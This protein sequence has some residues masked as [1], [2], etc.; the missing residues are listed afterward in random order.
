M[1]GIPPP[2]SS[3]ADDVVWAL[4]TAATQ[5]ERGEQRDA[6]A[7]LQ[8][9][10]RAA[11][12]EGNDARAIELGRLAAELLDSFPPEAPRPD[13]SAPPAAAGEDDISL[14]SAI[15]VAVT[16]EREHGAG[17][18]ADDEV[19][20][21]APPMAV[22]DRPGAIQDARL[23]DFRTARSFVGVRDAKPFIDAIEREAESVGPRPPRR[24]PP[25]PPP[26]AART[27]RPASPVALPPPTGGQQEPPSLEPVSL[28]PVSLEPDS[29]EDERAEPPS[30]ET[31]AGE[32]PV[33]R[34][35]VASQVPEQESAEAPQDS[36]KRRRATMPSLSSEA[37]K[38]RAMERDAHGSTP[39]GPLANAEPA[40]ES[41]P[42]TAAS[43]PAAASLP[44]SSRLVSLSAFEAFS[45]VPEDELAQFE[46]QAEVQRV[47]CDEEVSGFGL[48]LVLDGELQVAAI[49]SD[50][51]AAK[52]GA[53][54]VL[55]MRGSVPGAVEVRL[56]C[57]SAVATVA[58]WSEAVVQEAF[59]ALPW[60][61]EE[62]RNR[63]NRVHALVGAT[64]GPLGDELDA[65][66]LAELAGHMQVRVLVAHEQVMQAGGELP[67]LMVVGFGLLEQ[68]GEAEPG[69]AW[70]SGDLVFPSAVLEGG[71]APAT[72]RAGPSGAVVLWVERAVT[73]E[74]FM[75]FPPLLDLLV[76]L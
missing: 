45:D 7:W 23:R 46:A 1:A 49:V 4:Q 37:A 59:G 9:A 63:A 50:V 3:D 68:A 57:A 41:P 21:S 62:L 47:A 14:S 29:A 34:P 36:D 22:L 69:A 38:A 66:L 6:V 52:V 25:P 76:R 42:E 2:S 24:R 43:V 75:T 72:V 40:R 44:A 39:E 67:G 71:A 74:L 10:A 65:G 48:A 11:G 13:A 64:L 35:K 19:V 32:V 26:L 8:R 30:F 61:E 70:G 15:E 33:E 60:V 28:E 54:S 73:Q 18:E 5:W 56:V 51:V 31:S 55:R 20:T 16:V 27:Q 58:T 17:E 53:G 12:D